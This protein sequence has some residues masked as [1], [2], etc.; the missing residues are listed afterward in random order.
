MVLAGDLLAVAARRVVIELATAKS[1]EPMQ[2]LKQALEAY[3]TA[4]IG[5]KTNPD[6]QRMTVPEWDPAPETE[7]SV[8]Q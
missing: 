6:P 2:R 4:R 8:P 7:R 5:D 1:W 3:E